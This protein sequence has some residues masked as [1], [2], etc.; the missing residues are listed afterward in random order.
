VY[1]S[2]SAISDA[3]VNCGNCKIFCPVSAIKNRV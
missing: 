3:C 1:D 2:S